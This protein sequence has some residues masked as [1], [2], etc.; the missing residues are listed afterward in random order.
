MA[1]RDMGKTSAIWPAGKRATRNKSRTPRRVGSATALKTISDEYVTDRSRIICNYMVTYS[2]CQAG[3]PGS[4]TMTRCTLHLTTE[5]FGARHQNQKPRIQSFS[6][7]WTVRRS[8]LQPVGAS[9]AR[10]RS[11]ILSETNRN[12]VYKSERQFG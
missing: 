5:I 2:G 9:G 4:I 8:L 7:Y 1:G 12:S 3:F 10:L 6:D 11:T